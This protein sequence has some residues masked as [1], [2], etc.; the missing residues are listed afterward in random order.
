VKSGE[1]IYFDGQRGTGF[2]SGTDGNR[3]VFDV[4]DLAGD[5]QVAKGAKVAFE[6]DGDRARQIGLQVPARQSTPYVPRGGVQQEAAGEGGAALL[7]EPAVTPG[8]FSY[9]R[10]CVT[11]GYVRFSGR[12]RRREYWSFILISLICFAIVGGIGFA[13]GTALGF[14]EAEEPTV[15]ALA[16]FCLWLYLILPSLSVLVRRVHDIGLSGWFVLLGLVPM[17]GSLII[18]VFTLVGSQKH[19]NKWGPVPTGVHI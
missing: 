6:A 17:I 13:A 16:L 15:S 4:S 7:A 3:Y 18:L 8:L 10:Y 12:A 9:F 14:D 5:G 2:I 1:V 19:D 11:S